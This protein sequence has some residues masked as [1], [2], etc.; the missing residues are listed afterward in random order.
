M[1]ANRKAVGK[2][3]GDLADE[4]EPAALT[5]RAR[6]VR[7]YRGCRDLTRAATFDHFS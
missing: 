6:G 3:I 2:A 4:N 1:I 5:G 7:I